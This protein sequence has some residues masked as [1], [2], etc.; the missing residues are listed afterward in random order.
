[1]VLDMY[2]GGSREKWITHEYWTLYLSNTTNKLVFTTRGSSRELHL[3][4]INRLGR[5]INEPLQTS[6]RHTPRMVCVWPS[7]AC[8]SWRAWQYPPQPAEGRTG[9]PNPSSSWRSSTRTAW[10]CSRPLRTPTTQSCPGTGTGTWT[11]AEVKTSRCSLWVGWGY[12]TLRSLG[13]PSSA[14]KLQSKKENRGLFK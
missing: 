7:L 13:A 6:R 4:L 11:T 1:M 10:L 8:A 3:L 12:P 2:V 5:L 9:G 14:K